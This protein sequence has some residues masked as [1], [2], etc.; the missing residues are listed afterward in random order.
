MAIKK[1]IWSK[2]AQ[3]ELNK[4]LE[5]YVERNKSS[6]YS[7]KLLDQVETLTQNL[8]KNPLISRIS[9]NK[10]TRVIPLESFLVFYEIES[11]YIQ[12]VSFWDNRQDVEKR[13][14]H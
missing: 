14:D 9:K 5:F 10:I 4:V 11:N 3:R 12:I 7:L 2:R 1:I 13:V 6:S 8:S